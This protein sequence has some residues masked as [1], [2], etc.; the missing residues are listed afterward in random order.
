[1]FDRLNDIC[2]FLDE[3]GTTN[4]PTLNEDH[5]FAFGG[6]LV[7]ELDFT[8]MR[9]LSDALAVTVGNR[10]FKYR[11][12]Q[13]S[14]A[15]RT[16]FIDA[17]NETNV[18]AVAIYVPGGSLLEEKRR[19]IA[20]MEDLGSDDDGGTAQAAQELQADKAGTSI[21]YYIEMLAAAFLQLSAVRR[22][23]FTLFWDRR[24]DL[25]TVLSGCINWQDLVAPTPLHRH[26]DVDFGGRAEGEAIAL[27]RVAGVVAGDVCQFFRNHLSRIE[28]HLPSKHRFDVFPEPF[29]ANEV[30]AAMKVA[31]VWERLADANPNDAARD[32]CIIQGYFRSFAKSLMTFL[33]RDGRM[34]HLHVLSGRHFT[35]HQLPD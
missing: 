13:R 2:I 5:D 29:D 8:S 23:R 12:V 6:I 7:N 31:D 28:A 34:V 24:S 32:T 17:M 33:T 20:E 14:S 4:R 16:R 15:A 25:D 18:E 35:L 21:R 3:S 11:D 9:R 26:S 1:M 10:D 19:A 30:M 22:Q 27:T